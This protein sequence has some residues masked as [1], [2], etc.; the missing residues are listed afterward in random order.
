MTPRMIVNALGAAVLAA[1]PVNGLF[2]HDNNVEDQEAR[3]PGRGE[4]AD[5]PK[6]DGHTWEF[7]YERLFVKCSFVKKTFFR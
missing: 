5:N 7:S 2:D 1:R 3:H 6:F 4:R